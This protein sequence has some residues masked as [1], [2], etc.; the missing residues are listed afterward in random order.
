MKAILVR[1][2]KLLVAVLEEMGSMHSSAGMRQKLAPAA[3]DVWLNKD[4]VMDL[5]CITESTFYRRLAES[6]W[7]RKR[8]GRE[9]YY[10]KSSVI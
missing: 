7:V 9:W 6:N 4:A 2:E 10:L 8:N 5:L 1:I 3:H